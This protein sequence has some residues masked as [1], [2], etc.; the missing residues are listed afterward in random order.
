MTL[1]VTGEHFQLLR[2]EG[3]ELR[4]A[5][6]LGDGSESGEEIGKDAQD[7]IW[8]DLCGGLEGEASDD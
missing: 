2:V 5:Q 4:A 8:L 3:L 6:S 1:G 7:G